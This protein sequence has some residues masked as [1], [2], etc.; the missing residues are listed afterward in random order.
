MNSNQAWD[1]AGLAR[2]DGD[3]VDELRW[4]A[5]ARRLDEEERASRPHTPPTH[6][7]E[8]THSV[9]YHFSRCVVVNCTC[10]KQWRRW[11]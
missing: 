8:C 5:E 11:S 2:Q 1:M 9:S 4:T 7:N 10:T 6:C 3:K